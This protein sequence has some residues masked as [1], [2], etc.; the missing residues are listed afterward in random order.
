MLDARTKRILGLALAGYLLLGTILSM[1]APSIGNPMLAIFF[2]V[3][4]AYGVWVLVVRSDIL[5]VA[6]YRGRVAEPAVPALKWTGRS[7]DVQIRSTTT[8]DSGFGC[9]APE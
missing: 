2:V 9:A 6:S 3:V 8:L 1:V 5:N 7:E 4:I